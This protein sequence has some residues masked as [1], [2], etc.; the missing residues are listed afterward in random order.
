[1]RSQPG[2]HRKRTGRCAPWPPT[3][4]PR[5]LRCRTTPSGASCAAK[6]SA[7][8]KTLLASETE[9]PDLARRRTRWRTHQH[10]FDPARLVFVDETWAKTN[11]TRTRGWSPR[12]TPLLAKVPHGHWKTLTFLA[13]LRHDRIVAPCVIDGP[14]NGLSFTAWVSQFLAPT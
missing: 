11:M 8:K 4:E 5:A 9:R 6:A 10:R 13:G 7:A 3:C 12:G 1:M 2:W 14:I